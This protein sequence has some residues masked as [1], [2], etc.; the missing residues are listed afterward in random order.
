MK[1]FAYRWSQRFFRFA[2]YGSVGAITVFM[3]AFVV[4]LEGRLDLKFWHDE[5]LESEFT[6]ESEVS[7]FSDYLKLEQKLFN[8]LDALVKKNIE[9]TD[10]SQLNRFYEKSLSH[11]ARWPRNWNRSFELTHDAP[12]AG[13]LLLHG[14]SDS[15]YSLRALGSDLHKAGAWVTGLRL[16]GHGTMPSE[17][18]DLDWQD[19]AAAVRIAIQHLR[20]KVGDKPIYVLGYSTGGAL[21]VH[22]VSA[23]LL[24]GQVPEIDGL[25]MISPA[26]GVTSLAAFAVWQARLGH[27]LGLD[28]LAWNSIQP[29]YD[30]FK[31][32]SF[33]VNAGDQ[34]YRLTD[35][36]RLDLDQL[37][38]SGHMLQFPKVLAFQS[39]VDATVS[40][41]ALINGFFKHLP[42]RKHELVLFDINRHAEIERL[43]TNDPGYAINTMLE[44][45]KLDFTLTLITND[46]ND[47]TELISLQ[48]TQNGAPPERTSLSMAWPDDIYSLSHVALPFPANDPLYGDGKDVKKSPGVHLGN[49]AFRGERGLLQIPAAEMLRQRWN[50]FYDHMRDHILAFMGLTA[51]E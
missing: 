24:D 30:P 39:V 15:P 17:L 4:Y 6:A 27:L 43:L 8:E 47:S 20:T 44:N 38:K 51:S 42:D 49:L 23:K 5:E 18:I 28:K 7:N 34:V 48:N 35:R 26:I 19:M 36:I 33:A 12:R 2:V 40:T 46:K 9:E 50:P 10:Y 11:P 25:V 14:M 13:V 21:A 41:P 31:Y 16:P 37:S 22:H 29:E 32:V 3:V 1:S 45:P